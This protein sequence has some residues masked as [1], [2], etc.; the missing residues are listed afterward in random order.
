[1]AGTPEVNYSKSTTTLKSPPSVGENINLFL[2]PGDELSLGVDLSKA[3]LQIVG[4]D[5]I[6]TLPNGGQITFVSLGMMAFEAN[7]PIVKLPSGMVMHVEQILNKI[8]DIGQVPKD[9][10]LVS[11]P[12]S[13]QSEQDHSAKNEQSKKDESP[14]NDYNAYY[15]DPQP[16]IKP[17][18]NTNAKESSGKYLHEAVTEYT[19]NNPAVS[20]STEKNKHMDEQSKSKDNIADVSA[21]LSFDLGFYQI[22]SSD[23]LS[24]GITTVLGGTGSALG[25]VSKSAAAQFQAETLDY[26]NDAYPT[27]ITAD[28]PNL[29]NDTYLTKL[30]RLTVSQP[31]GFAITDITI[32]GLT[33][34]FQILNSDFTS[35]NSTGGGWSLASGTGF[36]STATDG[37]Q[38][39]EFYIRYAP[40][41]ANMTLNYDYLMK[42]NLTSQFDMANVPVS[43][44]GEVVV[45]ELTTLTNYKDVG[46]IVKDVN[47][48]SD[49]TYSGKYANGFVVDTTPNENIIYTSKSNSTVYGGLSS[50]A[51]YGNIGNDTLNG[52]KGNDTLSG[53]AGANILNGGDGIDTVSYEYMTKYSNDFL[54]NHL[55]T[56]DPST[57]SVYANDNKG[58]HVDLQAGIATGKTVYD[59]TSDIATG[60]E[61]RSI[62]D[63]ISGV[64][65]V[66]GSKYD[67]TLRGDAGNNKLVGGEGNDTL[68]G[69]D[70]V[71]WLDGGS[72]NDWL[73]GSTNDYM[74][75]G[76][77]NTD[78]IDFSN[79]SNGIIIT[80]NNSANGTLGNINSSSATTIVK[81]VENVAGTQYKDIINGDSADNLLIG[82]YDHSAFSVT[83][84]DDTITGGAGAD[85]IVGDVMIDSVVASV[86]YAGSDILSG[87]AANDTIYGDSA[88]ILSN[89]EVEVSAD[90][91]VEYIRNTD[92][93]AT[94]AT[95]HGG[96]DTLQGGAGDDYINGGSG[97]DTVDFSSSSSKVYVNLN[98]TVA[99]GDGNDKI[100]NVENI[101]GS[102]STLG[103]TLIGNNLVNTISGSSGGDTLSGLGGN[104]T[105]DGKTG[106]DWVDY[107]YASSVSVNLTDGT[108]VVSGSDSDTLISIENVIGSSGADVLTGA[109]GS[110][111]T[112][113][114]KDGND[115]FYGYLD[116]DT[117]DGGSGIDTVDY[118]NISSKVNIT[119]GGTNNDKLVDIENIYASSNK[120]TL[121]GSSDVNI[122]DGRGDNDT[123]SGL[124]GD[125]TLLGGDGNDTLI[126]GSGAD[127][128]SGGNGQDMADYS[129]SNA[130][131]V[132]LTTNSVSDGLG[133]TDTLSSIE[134]IKG[135]LFQD[136]MTGSN[137]S[138]TFI[139]MDGN[140]TFYA[141]GGNDIYYGADSGVVSDSY[142][143]RVD[144]STLASINNIVA[145]LSTNNVYLRDASNATLSTDTLYSIE[146][147]YGTMGDDTLKGGTGSSN[148][149]Y[150]NDGNDTLTGNLDGDY[151]DGANG[152][153]LA[154]YSARTQNLTV[155]LSLSSKNIYLSGTTP[156]TSNSDTLA[157]IQNIS[158]GSG[159]DTITGNSADNTLKAG[160][161]SDTLYGGIGADL[162]YGEAGDD[163]FIGGAG[164]DTFYGGMSSVLD[165]GNDTADY[166]TA[167]FS[168]D[169]NL[170]TG[171]VTGNAAT[172]GTDTLY[173]IENVIGST[174]DDTLKGKV[175]VANTLKGGSG[176][177]TLY[178]GL[179]GDYLDGGTGTNRVDYSAET[180]DVSINLT[181]SKANYTA[182]PL[183][184]D[185]LLTLQNATSGSGNDTLVGKSGT[186]NILKSG[187]GND[188]LTGN[189]DGDTLDG[190]GG[191]DT[192]SYS[193]LATSTTVDL[194]TKT[195][196]STSSLS[197]KDY[198][199]NVELVQTGSGAD[200]ITLSGSSDTGAFTIDGGSGI[201]TID[202]SAISENIT[203]TMAGASDA[204]VVVGTVDSNDDVIRNIENVKGSKVADTITGDALTNVIYGNEGND[205]LSGGANN[206]TLYGGADNDILYG[207]VGVDSLYGEAGDDTIVIAATDVDGSSDRYDGGT[208]IDTI[209]Y[210]ILSDNLNVTL[211]AAAA[212]TAT[213]T[214]ANIGADTLYN[215]E[216]VI[217]GSGNDTLNGDFQANILIG[218]AGNDTLK[219]GSGADTLYG[220]DS[221]NTLSGNDLLEGGDGDDTLYAGLGDDIL[222]GGSGNDTF[223]GGTGNDTLDYSTAGVAITATLGSSL[224]TGEG[225]DVVDL[226]SIEVLKAGSSADVITMANSGVLS[227]IYAGAGNDIITGGSQVDTI[228]GEAGADTIRGN[229]GADIIVGGDGD[230]LFYG[231]IDGDVITGGESGETSGDTIDFSDVSTALVVD[232]V[233]GTVN[234]TASTFS[235]IENITGGLGNDTVYGDAN[236]NTLK[237]GSGDDTI[238]TSAGVDYIDGGSGNNDWIDFSAIVATPININL[239][240]Q[241]IIN[242]GYGNTETIVN[243]ENI[244]AGSGSDTLY[245]DGMNNTIYGNLGI[246]QLSG[247]DGNDLLY[248]DN[249]GNTH[250]TTDGHNT[251]DGGAGSDT[252]YAGDSG[253]TLIGGAGADTLYGAAGADTL[254]GGTGDDTLDGGTGIDVADYRSASAKVVIASVS[255]NVNDTTDLTT[256][257]LSGTEGTDII[258]NTVEVIYGSS[259]Y[260]D[261]MN[262]NANANTF[263]GWGGNDTINGGFGDDTL[264]GGVGDD[265]IAGNGGNDFLVGGDSVGILAGWDTVDYASDTAG[266]TVNLTTGTATGTSAGNDTLSGFSRVLG[267]DYADTLTGNVGADDLRGGGGDDWFVMTAGNDT[268]YGGTTLQTNGD[269]V[270][271]INAATAGI[272][273]NLATNNASGTDIGTDVIYEVENVSGSNFA[274]TITGDANA[275]ILVGRALNDTIL[276]GAGND[277][278]YGDDNSGAVVDG[279]QTGNDS[280]FG[281]DGN[282]TIYGGLGNDSLWG[283]NNNDTLY[284]GSGNDYLNGESGINV[285]DGGA[286]N[287][288]FELAD[289]TATNTL[290]GG[291]GTDTVS[292]YYTGSAVTVNLG[293]LSSNQATGGAGTVNFI[294]AIENVSG[295]GYNDVIT[296]NALDNVINGNDGND[297]LYGAGGIDTIYGGAG[298]D[299]LY[300]DS[301]VPTLSDGS[302]TLYGGDGNDTLY[303]SLGN[304]TL[305]GENNDDT[306][307]AMSSNDGS[308][309]IDGGQGTDTADY[310]AVTANIN[311]TLA[312]AAVATVSVTGG[313]NDTIVNVENFI[314]GSGNDTITGSASN[315][316]L[317]GSA[318]DDTLMGGA[319]N[320][321]LTDSIGNNTFVGGAGD[322]TINGTGATSSWLDYSLDGIT[323]GAVTN[324]NTAINQVIS[325]NRGND[326]ITGVNNITGSA[327]NDIFY[328]NSNVN[329]ING[330]AGDDAIEGYGGSDILD[331]GSNTVAGD[332]V[333][334]FNENKIS[335]TLNDSGT[336]SVG[337]WNGSNYTTEV[338]TISN[339]EN[340]S[341][342]N[343]GADIILGN[344]SNNTIWGN[345][346]ND[347][348]FGGAGND[349]IDGGSDN[350]TIAGG[351][352]VDILS[353][354]SGNDA[355]RGGGTAYN[356]GSA[357]G[358]ADTLYGNSGDDVLY[359]M[360]DGDTLY[361]GDNATTFNGS[362]TLNYSELGAGSAVYVDINA[363]AGLSFAQLTTNAAIKDTIF[364]FNNVTGSNGD[365]TIVG[366]VNNNSLSAGSGNDILYMSSVATVSSVS[367]AGTDNIDMGTGDDNLYIFASELTSSDIING[368]AG[369]DTITFRD[370]G[371]ISDVT[372]F[373][374]VSNV[375]FVQ[376]ADVVNTISLDTTKLNDVKLIGGTTTD[377][378]N[379]AITNFD[380]HDSIDGASGNDTLSF[381]TAGTLT[382]L[383][384]S[385]ISNIEKIQLAN[386]T[387]TVTVDISSVGGGV[388]TLY[389]NSAGGTNIYNYSLSNLTSVDKIVG[390]GASTTDM[391][392]FLDAGTIADD[393][394][395][396]GLSFIDQ[397]KLANGTNT[398]NIGTNEAQLSGVSIL[399]NSG[400]DTFVYTSAALTDGTA[401]AKLAGSGGN[402]ILQ[403]MGS[404]SVV[405]ANLS[406]FTG[407]N[408]LNLNSYT[409]TIALGSNA[410]T[411]GLTTIDASGNAGTVSIDASG[412]SSAVTI[413]A[414]NANGSTYKG[415]AAAGDILNINNALTSQNA[416]SITGIETINV[417]ANST[418]TGDI[419]GVT[420][421]SIAGAKTLNVDASAISSDTMNI[422]NSGTLVIN[423]TNSS[424]LS[425]LTFTGAGALQINGTGGNDSITLNSTLTSYTGTITIDGGAGDDILVGS[426]KNDTIFGGAGADTLTGGAGTDR[427]DGGE[428][429]DV[430]RFTALADISADIITDTGSSGTDLIFM[431]A[432]GSF[433]LAGI[434]VSGMEGLKFYQGAGAQTLTISKAQAALYSDFIGYSGATD[435]VAVTGVTSSL[436]M[437]SGKTYTNIAKVSVD[438]SSASA[439]L[440]LTG[441]STVSN[442][443]TGGSGNDTIIAGTLAD[444]LAGG[445]GNDTFKMDSNYLTSADTISDTSG[446]DTLEITNA[447]VTITDAQLT[448]VTNVEI[449]KLAAGSSV[450][451]GAEANN[452]GNGFTTVN[453]SAGGT[454]T[455]TNSAIN[456]LTV[457]GGAGADTLNVSGSVTINASNLSSVE[458]LNITS[459]SSAMSGTLSVATTT[460]SSGATLTTATPSTALSSSTINVS[461]TLSAT[462][463]NGTDIS[464][465][466]L[467]SGGTASF[468]LSSGGTFDASVVGF[469]KDPNGL[470]KIYGNTG[471]E[472]I[473]IDSAKFTNAG[474]LI[475]D[476]TG[477]SE[478]DTLIV[479]GSNAIDFT[480]ISGMEIID[481][482]NYNGTTLTTNTTTGETIKIDSAYTSIN[483]G[484][485]TDQLYITANSVDLSGATLSNIESYYVASGATLTLKASDVSGKAVSSAGNI[486][487]IHSADSSYD[488]SSIATSGTK[489]LEFSATSTF[490][491]T[492]GSVSTISVDNGITATMTAS[493][494]N[495]KTAILSGAGALDITAGATA[496]ANNFANLTNSISGNVTLNVTSVLDL[497]TATLGSALDKLNTSA[498]VTLSGAQAN[499]ISQYSGAGNIT[500]E[501]GTASS[502]DLSIKTL[503]GYSGAFTFNDGTGVQTLTGT[504]NNDIYN[505]DNASVNIFAN[506]GND[507][508]NILSS[509]GS[510]LS[511]GIDGGGGADVL[512]IN[513]SGLTFNAS[514]ITAVEVININQSTTFTGS[515]SATTTT[516]AS[517]VTLSADASVISGETI[518]GTGILSV[519]NLDAT[520][521]ADFSAVAGATTLNVDWS[522]TGTYTGNLTNVD[523]L[524]ISSGTMS[525]T[526]D[527]LAGHTTTGT[528]ALI[529]DVDSNL[530]FTWS[531][532]AASL[533]ETVNFTGGTTYT[534][535]LTNVDAITLASGVSVDISGA[536]I[537]ATT[538][539]VTGAGGSESLTLNSSFLHVTSSVDLGGA[540]D[541]LS[542]TG[543]TTLTATDFGKIQN[544]ETLDLNNY[545]GTADLTSTSGITQLNTGSGV[546]S[547]T[548]DYAMNVT[549]SGGV[550]TLYTTASMNLSSN[551]LSG[552]ETLSVASGTT[553]TLDYDD[554]GTGKITTLTGSGSVSVNGA[555]SMDI[556]S[557]NIAG[558]GSDKL[559]ITGTAGA[560]SLVLDFSQLDKIQ[561]NG[562]NG[563]DTVSLTGSN[564]SVFNDS[565]AF[566]NIETLDISSL[567]LDSGGLT[568]NASSLYAFDSN[569]TSLSD[570]L[571][572]DVANAQLGNISLSNIASVNGVSDADHIWSLAA[573]GDYTITTTNSET[574]YMHVV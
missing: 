414:T 457:I 229:A 203:L 407:I 188:T 107:S 482:T 221:A 351:V 555:T 512:N 294:D 358:F 40:N 242:D 383:M 90:Q 327:Y 326:I 340:I 227:T 304:D 337:V 315:N 121:V 540:S 285:L 8:Q 322:D 423:N 268:I 172:E 118:G 535:A 135:S 513:K 339:F 519:T 280:L 129:A 382:D 186:V 449:L 530:A 302:N 521:G 395:F 197:N 123:L 392:Q 65:Y 534:Q 305:Y 486:V 559:G 60:E 444:T 484:G 502:V 247:N 377:I 194:S 216:N 55:A 287:D 97:Y 468:T 371:T 363:T 222:R 108:G 202:Y 3:T 274:D 253:D 427:L 517:G 51:I 23:S 415:S 506:F 114:G 230:D 85:T 387:N 198:F 48:E 157:N 63:T 405:N 28:N 325:T 1:M 569:T 261:T 560:D 71:D 539:S 417:N 499:V 193:S 206:D 139:G 273:V 343:N 174:L 472:T 29:V 372:K 341:G 239:S 527:I 418:F 81:N 181:T 431:D 573:A 165:S 498:L 306:I 345:V 571:T 425:G 7:A 453:L 170:A 568:I 89:T 454:N 445:S 124:A 324:L 164:N 368:N 136:V 357:D 332:T 552:I 480:K 313:N 308:D 335:V 553:T 291:V 119:L 317:N 270:D 467:N 348:L 146:E 212:G 110:V 493:A 432:S 240:T 38:I 355:L 494:L 548:I 366:N 284:G 6:A 318:G 329:T 235:E 434:S 277:L 246:D 338:D 83:A 373:Q 79:N 529:V 352:G 256:G 53:G 379:Y 80:L 208:G 508:I 88:P 344:A 298:A 260:G 126:G 265:T 410:T 466:T 213:T 541:T 10:I 278:L 491:G 249:V 514:N 117:L 259:G 37:G 507:T 564:A 409:G 303:G 310:T 9:S 243:I 130:I 127:V 296:G 264:Y 211:N 275:N 478:T 364:G 516:I 50:D 131:T 474:D 100:V 283:G 252:L 481:L 75:D 422:A 489:T 231:N 424:V 69:R 546:N 471:Y 436:D 166:T 433:S 96:N 248:G 137:A 545:T 82:G 147:V 460:I 122:L 204:I 538:T 380:N 510:N 74:I 524:N 528:G 19:S 30:V 565:T 485:G 144:Y 394:R 109:Q 14:V 462:N 435:T 328:G 461:G 476:S 56:I 245:G 526:D 73:I 177:D 442:T 250:T 18:D 346:G 297:T 217:A 33:D 389:A 128:L 11:G 515:L 558:L 475:S 251:L 16:F 20:D 244:N 557:E 375:E 120:D 509:L 441:A 132:N 87:G 311:V 224:I 171:I 27:V 93:D 133:G 563:S 500:V 207:G 469:S 262:G 155:D 209:D 152:V 390:G 200:N 182:T 505:V 437:D 68:E 199:D 307:V 215:I 159:A 566:S 167:L 17:Q 254:I 5:V 232:M 376:F 271:F 402:D 411:M 4:G 134:I 241:K 175:G 149:L 495:G 150:G 488:L 448:N 362:D 490:S 347:S 196:A 316:Y 156:S 533:N 393:T 282:D 549:D 295:S 399:G 520:L 388:A 429:G 299:K 416:S 384:L 54:F 398:F 189:F 195:I 210:S 281:Q 91:S 52:D 319:G 479:T 255:A 522:G 13:L 257:V 386:G 99:T 525:V 292:F 168:I 45:P 228:Y 403:I 184:Y 47:S 31:I 92:T 34:A 293:T 191:I 269:T 459:G 412:M 77:D 314:G 238:F 483:A 42:V 365:D 44:Q 2:R 430:Y 547:T 32:L 342:S 15:V 161:G 406:G 532:I 440:T 543:N 300:G 173:G 458:N 542:V 361:G 473:T 41:S 463:V 36:T 115:L 413:N 258:T 312:D 163:T 503:A 309:V 455:V 333:S 103:D 125:D 279:I 106:S 46:V 353:G 354:G 142:K 39:I 218:N 385:S 220:D 439:A 428:D 225:A 567:G 266:V 536:T 180:S 349:S 487:V 561:F 43:K 179:D 154:D 101:I 187:L 214:S 24:G 518:N 350:D 420:N 360:L 556:H 226:T 356:N 98:D 289:A 452:G 330:G 61:T 544:V 49:Y 59:A 336:S 86:I 438:A 223:Y 138:D 22:K 145:D 140:D 111:N 178:G 367:N 192:L 148:T 492:L 116:G 374:N 286:G 450:T 370:G 35:A 396:S 501:V 66:I 391:I 141:T 421:L 397:I 531:N 523:A 84:N 511:G 57:G 67:D 320:D 236:A 102:N 554:L 62:S 497:T 64:E 369:S 331:G 151:L 290:T 443:I 446:T 104:D 496:A 158:T 272:I 78:T 21:A 400:I 419:T 323:E 551:T 176:N 574:L 185:T 464:H 321:T 572:L 404:T 233:A 234:T 381:T 113:L 72:G 237:G 570:A 169:A 25:N 190:E 456:N 205:I 267:S 465:V 219:G 70:G 562:G 26:R 301:A 550:D 94:L 426:S 153:N 470:L 401:N 537:G 143:D 359:G 477:A 12:V 112:L 276:A 183:V 162:L 58:I 160:S 447:G 288:Y 105:L 504:M 95:I 451:L 408:T 263:Y 334:Y 201:D 76:G 378:F